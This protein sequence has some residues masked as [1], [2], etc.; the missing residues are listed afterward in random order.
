MIFFELSISNFFVFV[1]TFLFQDLDSKI[2]DINAHPNLQKTKIWLWSSLR[3][4]LLR[5][6]HLHRSFSLVEPHFDTLETN[7]C[8]IC[9]F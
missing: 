6:K 7:I 3:I 9:K 2:D 5:S 4:N 8:N 1:Y